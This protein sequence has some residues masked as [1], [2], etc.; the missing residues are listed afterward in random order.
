MSLDS[1]NLAFT[2]A[3]IR[4]H[5]DKF[6]NI[7]SNGVE[8]TYCF[9]PSFHMDILTSGCKDKKP[10]ISAPPLGKKQKAGIDSLFV[11]N[12]CLLLTSCHIHMTLQ[13]YRKFLYYK[14]F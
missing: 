14:G 11:I 13:M 2:N 1:D 10:R 12:T 9:C 4:L 3:F 7:H 6:L 8:N 5:S